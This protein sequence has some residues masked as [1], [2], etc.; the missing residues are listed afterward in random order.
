[1][2]ALAFP[3]PVRVNR[4][5]LRHALRSWERRCGCGYIT[6]CVICARLLP[7]KRTYADVCRERC[8]ARLTELR[9]IYR[10]GLPWQ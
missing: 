2:V 7:M 5:S 10:E 3:A 6:T 9:A 1:M 4:H 8:F